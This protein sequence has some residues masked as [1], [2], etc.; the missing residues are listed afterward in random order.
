MKLHAIV[1]AAAAVL[2]S[3]GMSACASESVS[4][5]ANELPAKARN[6][7]SQNFTS[8]VSVIDIEKSMGSV[9]EY[10]VVLSDGIEIS[11]TGSGEWKSI[12]TPNNVPVPEGLVPTSIAR[13]VAEKHAGAFVVGL[14]KEK[15]G[16]DVTL[17]NGLKIEFDQGGNFIK[18]DK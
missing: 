6:L 5:D 13:F 17:S 1:L 12:D 4:H 16:F 14:E 11:F 18:Y 10:E 3:T 2:M 7:I 9:K 15:N 8:A